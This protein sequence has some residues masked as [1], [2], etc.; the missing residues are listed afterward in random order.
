VR[1][2]HQEPTGENIAARGGAFQP[3]TESENQ[4]QRE[5]RNKEEHD[6]SKPRSCESVKSRVRAA[7]PSIYAC[8]PGIM[9]ASSCPQWS[10]MGPPGY[11]KT[12]IH[13]PICCTRRSAYRPVGGRLVAAFILFVASVL[14]LLEPAAATSGTSSS[15]VISFR[16]RLR[17]SV[18]SSRKRRTLQRQFVGT[19]RFSPNIFATT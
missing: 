10:P 12:R 16:S 7:P 15:F 17:A 5:G 9:A 4:T 8:E 14:V 11:P 19:S 18:P 6:E 1:R 2:R 13:T 3:T